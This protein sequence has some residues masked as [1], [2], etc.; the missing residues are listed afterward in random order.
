MPTQIWINE[1]KN[2]YRTSKH[3]ASDF[4]LHENWNGYK[5]YARTK[6]Q[7]PSRVAYALS[8]KRSQ[9]YALVSMKATGL[10]IMGP[11]RYDCSFV[12]Q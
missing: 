11:M 10:N 1:E 4:S 2:E 6:V 7:R 12:A 8:L 9:G 5:L 3:Q